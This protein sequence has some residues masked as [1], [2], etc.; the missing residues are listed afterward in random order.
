MILGSKNHTVGD[1]RLWRLD[2]DRWLDNT[3]TIADATVTSSSTSCTAS[4]V[5]VLGREITFFLTGGTLNETLT[6]SVQMTDSLGNVKH[7]SIL[8]TVVAP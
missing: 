1:T 6:V 7:D 3:A 2:Y 4:Q 8:F 5:T